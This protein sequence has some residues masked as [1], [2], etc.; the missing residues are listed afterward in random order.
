MA[1]ARLVLTCRT[2]LATTHIKSVSRAKK[3]SR[4]A[5]KLGGALTH[6]VFPDKYVPE[7]HSTA[8][9]LLAPLDDVSPTKHKMHAVCPELPWY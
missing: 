4:V 6:Q 1:G 5:N 9:Q 8:L 3:Q 2:S 7:L